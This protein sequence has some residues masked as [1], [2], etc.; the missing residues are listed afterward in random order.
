MALVPPPQTAVA[1]MAAPVVVANLWQASQAPRDDRVVGRFWPTF[2]AILVGSWIGV[3]VLPRIDD[4]ALLSIVGGAVIVF[5]LLQGS[6][7]KLRIPAAPE[8]PAGVGFGLTSGAIS[9]LYVVAHAVL[10]RHPRPPFTLVLKRR[11][12]PRRAGHA[13]RP[14]SAKIHQ[15][16]PLPALDTGNPVVL[17]RCHPVAGAGLMGLIFGLNQITNLLCL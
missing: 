4:Q 3:A 1:L 5:A 2:A 7:Y 17:R 11:R 9:F 13:A 14:Q 6:S 16:T 10:G 15:R 8:K 12:R